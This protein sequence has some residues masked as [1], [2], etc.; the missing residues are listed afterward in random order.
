MNI[1]LAGDLFIPAKAC[2]DELDKIA[3][4]YKAHY[5]IIDW[6]TRDLEELN[7]RNIHIE[8]EGPAAES[9]PD[10]LRTLVKDADI[11]IVHFCP[12]SKEILCSGPRLK[13]IGT[14]R[15]GLSNI[16]VAV[17][18]ER[19]IDIVNTP[20]RLADSVSEFTVGL[21][22]AETR[23][24]ARAHEAIR[25]GCWM[26]NFSNTAF[27]FEL[28]DRTVGL[29]GF[30]EIGK[31][32]ARKLIN[33]DVR[34][35]AYDPFVSSDIMKEFNVR[36]VALNE[37]LPESDIV[38]IHTNISNATKS[39]IG[40]KEI[41]LMKPTGYLINTARAEIIDKEALYEALRAK[42]IAGAALDVFWNE[43]VDPS[44]PILQLENVTITSHLAGSTR[45]ALSKSMSKLTK[46]LQPYFKK[47]GRATGKGG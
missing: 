5:E 32:V 6:E 21:M 22:I 10:K 11:L 16:D 15:T 31:K 13:V 30:G 4:K 41:A 3:E 24:I 18:R 7:R 46:R 47:L 27:C 19:R 42:K 36:K 2:V 43:P 12:V 33:F 34:I 8:K 35:V 26:K 40:K 29:V 28:A 9:P 1:V 38:S 14:M 20:G 17:A 25:K 45:D 37:L 39:L 23:N 44:D